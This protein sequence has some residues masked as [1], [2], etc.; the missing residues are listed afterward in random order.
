M[1]DLSDREDDNIKIVNLNDTKQLLNNKKN[2][3]LLMVE[4]KIKNKFIERVNDSQMQLVEESCMN[5]SSSSSSSDEEIDNSRIRKSPICK[6]FLIDEKSQQIENSCSHHKTRLSQDACLNCDFSK[7]LKDSLDHMAF[8]SPTSNEIKQDKFYEELKFDSPTLEV[9]E[10]SE[11]QLNQTAET[12]LND[13]T[14]VNETIT[15]EP[16]EN[17]IND[18]SK[19]NVSQFE[20]NKSNLVDLSKLESGDRTS[21]S[22]S[23]GTFVLSDHSDDSFADER[24]YCEKENKYELKKRFAMEEKSIFTLE[25]NSN[26]T[27]LS[28]LKFNQIDSS[29]N[30]FTP[31]I[32]P[33][34]ESELNQE[35]KINNEPIVKYFKSEDKFKVVTINHYLFF[36]LSSKM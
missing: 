27:K 31:C 30:W 9:A 32:L 16:V 36:N 24:F 7:E 13:S 10:L 21:V 8:L 25:N 5:S 17:Q 11:N 28:N 22:M 35:F 2:N 12:F 23:E 33:P 6:Y 19:G 29:E 4:H 14:I 15:E 20:M 26:D 18:E 34:V 1:S 3:D